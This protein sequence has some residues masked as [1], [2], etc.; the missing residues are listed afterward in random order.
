MKWR[1][2][3][4]RRGGEGGR[5]GGGDGGCGRRDTAIEA[6]LRDLSPLKWELGR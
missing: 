6:A 3:S 4:W 1:V 5:S 2:F